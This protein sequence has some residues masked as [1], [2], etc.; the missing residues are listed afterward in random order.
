MSITWLY[1]INSWSI[2]GFLNLC[3]LFLSVQFLFGN[4][5]T[6]FINLVKIPSISCKAWECL[7]YCKLFEKGSLRNLRNELEQTQTQ[8]SH[9]W[10]HHKLSNCK[11]SVSIF[12]L[13]LSYVWVG[14]QDKVLVNVCKV[15]YHPIFYKLDRIKILDKL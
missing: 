14:L 9:R 6:D 8:T 5:V 3:I 10:N 7:K 13:L 15:W 4:C 1:L 2:L 12:S 11:F